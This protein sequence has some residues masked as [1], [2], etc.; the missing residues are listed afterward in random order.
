MLPSIPAQLF[1]TSTPSI[2]STSTKTP[3]PVY[4]GTPTKTATPRFTPTPTSLPIQ[5]DLIRRAV[6]AAPSPGNINIHM[7]HIKLE[8]DFSHPFQTDRSTFMYTMMIQTKNLALWSIMINKRAST[9]FKT[10]RPGTTGED[11]FCGEGIQISGRRL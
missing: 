3:T 8:R 9:L 7:E 10:S 6:A 1:P 2:T 5:S 11:R 4:T